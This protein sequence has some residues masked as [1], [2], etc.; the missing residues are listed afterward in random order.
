M[1]KPSAPGPSGF[2]DDAAAK[3]Y[4]RRNEGL[5]PISECLHFLMRLALA[6]LPTDAR[7]LCVGVGTGA[8]IL[9][10]AK[11]QPGWSFVGVDP[12]GGMLEVARQRLNEAGLDGRYSLIHGHV[13][14]VAEAE[15]DVVVSLLVAHFIKRPDRPAFYRAIH[16]RLKPGGRF[17]SAEISAELDAATFPAML[18]D[19][20]QVQAMMGT[21][22]ESLA[23]LPATLRD[24]LGIVP[25]EETEALWRE[26]GFA[27]P[28]P[29][30]QAFMIRGWHAIRT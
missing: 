14:D 8:E 11:A 27:T 4:D 18:A 29:F 3:A 19:W 15:F 25:P 13:D 26:A 16:D 1:N 21:T 9:S 2:F 20:S 22:P 12:A 5:W 17:V 23:A 24:V 10:L 28:V 30:F 7:V 6:E